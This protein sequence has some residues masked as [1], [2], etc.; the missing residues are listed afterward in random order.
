MHDTYIQ[1]R[2]GA[3]ALK[4]IER[5]ALEVFNGLGDEAFQ[6]LFGKAMPKHD[7][8]DV[9]QREREMTEF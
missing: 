1:L 4:A 3:K 7:F 2:G 5:L 6:N 9:I 8:C